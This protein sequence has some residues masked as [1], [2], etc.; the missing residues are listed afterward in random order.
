MREMYL[1][2]KEL[3]KRLQ[4]NSVPWVIELVGQLVSLLV[5]HDGEVSIR[6]YGALLHRGRMSGLLSCVLAVDGFVFVLELKF[7]HSVNTDSG[8]ITR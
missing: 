4:K 6:I 8:M 7:A 1:L 3:I 5:L 2:S